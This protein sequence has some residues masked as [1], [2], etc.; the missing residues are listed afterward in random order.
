MHQA[1]VE[2]LVEAGMKVLMTTIEVCLL[3]YDTPIWHIFHP[4]L[5]FESISCTRQY[6]WVLTVEE[7]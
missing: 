6:V 1:V 7:V 4:D 2:L 3:F 5:H